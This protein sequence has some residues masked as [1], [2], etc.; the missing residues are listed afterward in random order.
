[1]TTF[2]VVISD[3]LADPKVLCDT[4]DLDW[5]DPD[6]CAVRCYADERRDEI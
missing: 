2:A 4:L 6:L 5:G 3:L 1:M